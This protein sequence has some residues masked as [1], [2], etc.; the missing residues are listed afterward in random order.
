MLTRLPQTLRGFSRDREGTVAMLFSLSF[1]PMVLFIGSAVDYGRTIS[2]ST[3][4]QST[5]DATVLAAIKENSD[6]RV[7]RATAILDATMVNAN[8][9]VASRSFTNNADGSFTGTVTVNVPMTIM[10]SIVPT[11]A[12][13]RTTTAA[14]AAAG[15]PGTSGATEDSCIF[16]MGEDLQ[17]SSDTITFNG[18][19]NVNLT[20]C[21]LRSNKSM[22]CNGGATGAQT[23]AVG[24]IVGCS[25]PH[26][27]QAV[28]PDLYS[29]IASNIVKYCGTNAG[30]Y[31]W[32][33]NGSVPSAVANT[34][35]PVSRSGYTEIHVCGN[36]TLN[37]DDDHS[38]TGS[39]PATDTVV[40]VENGKIQIADSAYVK[41][42][43][44]TF[45]LAGGASSNIVD[46]P[47]GNGKTGTFDISGSTGTDNPWK[48]MALFQNPTH[49][50]GVD[51]TWK[52]GSWLKL[53]GVIYFP[54]AAFTV[55]GNITMGPT[56][57]AKV[58][59]GEFTLNGSVNLQQSSAGCATA[60]VT[61]Y[62]FP[63]TAAVAG[64]EMRI[65]N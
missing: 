19:P 11:V 52:P 1:V 56:A 8:W 6:S 58:V 22:K 43:R 51:T 34:I 41:A 59:T 40:V 20:G 47:N 55:Q 25:N 46:F 21:S 49:T 17:V 27:G 24:S 57:C 29:S 12:I 15:T 33:A 2:A 23:Y 26:S 7:T 18:S 53:S 45:V 50:S 39:S 62:T 9:S 31:S 28:T 35:I 61:Q 14:P 16:A 37:G 10:S 13:T 36:L 44:V 38:L 64:T 48:G 60:A 5:L 32:N 3:L 42:R 54:N 63:G 4:V 30:G 65:I